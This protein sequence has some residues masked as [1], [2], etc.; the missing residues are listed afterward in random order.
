MLRTK[1]L[2]RLYAGY[3]SIF[4]I[5]SVIIGSL[6]NKQ[7]K[8]NSLSEI[9]SSLASRAELLAEIAKPYLSKEKNLESESNLQYMLKRL[10]RNTSS[11]L[12]IITSEGMVL[13]DSRESPQQMDNHLGRPEIIDAQTHGSSIAT[14]YSQTLQQNMMYVAIHVTES[15]GTLG[16]VRVSTPLTTIE[17][18]LERLRNII[19]LASAAAAIIALFLGYLFARRFTKPLTQIT[20]TARA[21]SQGDY[22]RRAKVIYNDEIGT[23]AAAINQLATTSA[24]RFEK[25]TA[26][27]NRLAEIFAGMVE[28]VIGVDEKQNIIHINQ[29]A[30]RLLG[31]SM[32]ATIQKPL[33]Q[34]VRVQEIKDALEEA[35]NNQRVVRS[36]MRRMSEKN[37]FVL[38]IY[39]AALHDNQGTGTGAVI[40]LHDISE[41]DYLERVRQDFVANASH[42]LK[43]PITAIRGLTET[44]LDDPAMDMETRRAFTERINVQSRRLSSLVSDL[45]VISR[46][47]SGDNNDAI[48]R[49][50]LVEVLTQSANAARAT[51]QER[52]LALNLTLPDQSLWMRGDEQ[53][54]RQML[55]NLID[56]ALKYTPDGGS[57]DLAL[58]IQNDSAVISV[59]DTGIGIGPQYQSRIFE[60]FYRVDKARSRDL[61][62]TGLGLSIVKNI[63]DQHDGEILLKSQLG[64]GSTFTIKLPLHA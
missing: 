15:G 7:I 53:A 8:E 46:L 18:M 33:W 14:R 61:G 32:T 11:R 62:G 52:E 54:I 24:E 28:G 1:L 59:S 50:N 29:A 43:T 57:V 34:E 12:T 17:T 35:I 20:D 60:R 6:V 30:S 47:E 45:M 22:N 64:K 16:Y 36:Q 3:V 42:E 4:V 13:A 27:R 55:D 56:N 2:W 51:C 58:D 19:L 49:Y 31:I 10:D 44:I 5:T 21:I 23:L 25:I 9:E 63:V 41:I 48:Q 38:D 37:E 39:A 40:V 26:D